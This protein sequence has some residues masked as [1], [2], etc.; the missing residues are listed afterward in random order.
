M[1]VI[2]FYPLAI[3]SGLTYLAIGMQRIHYRVEEIQLTTQTGPNMSSFLTQVP[4]FLF[5]YARFI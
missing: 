5:L 3:Y 2:Q 1:N 4:S